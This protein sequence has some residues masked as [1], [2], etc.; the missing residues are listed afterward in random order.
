MSLA[1]RSLRSAGWTTLANL[2][3]LPVTFT[4]SV[5]LA[6]LLP[7]EYFGAFAWATA[8]VLLSGAPFE[9][10]LANAFLHRAPES[11][12]EPRAAAVFFTL[13]LAFMTLWALLLTAAVWLFFAD[14]LRRLA[15]TVLVG[16]TYLQSLMYVPRLT[17]VRRVEHRRPA[18]IDLT[19]SLVSAALSLAIA[20]TTRSIWALLISAVVGVVVSFAGFYLW[21][22]FWKPRLVWDPPAMRYFLGFGGKNLLNNLLDTALD[23]LD[24]LWT[25]YALGDRLLG[26]YSRAFKFATYPRLLLAN[27]LNAVVMGTY[28]EAKYDRRRLSRAFFQT[29]AFLARSGFLLAGW[30][31]VIAPEFIRLLIGARWL[32]MLSAFRL[33]LL[34]CMLDPIKASVANVLVAVGQP[35]KITRVRLAQLAVLLVGLFALG[36]RFEIAGVALA[37]D[38]MALCGALLALGY[39]RAHVDVSLWKLFAAPA[40]ALAAALGLTYAA[41]AALP[42]GAADWL[43]GALKTLVFGGVY[44][45]ALFALEGRQ[46]IETGREVWRLLALREALAGLPGR[47]E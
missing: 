31:A 21:Q 45:L 8:V 20:F 18:L 1:Q 43:S 22:P 30:L 14:A 19:I 25:G 16:A 32:P 38:L 6:R 2:I 47:V 4:Q 35:E 24:N 44:M 46:L 26:Y 5:L 39:A 42:P 3:A 12:E 28:A 23:N 10:G 17:L 13:R 11:E 37:M 9:F 40:L 36:A 41:A 7:V 29:N 33:M 27:P 34:F 15:L